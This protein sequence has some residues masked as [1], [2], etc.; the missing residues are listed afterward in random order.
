MTLTQ[1]DV[2]RIESRGHKGFYRENDG[3]DLQLLN[4]LLNREGRRLF[5]TST[6]CG[7]Y[8]IR[9]EGCRLYP[10]MLE[11]RR[12]EVVHDTFCP[13]AAEV[14]VP[15]DGEQRLRRSV[16]DE[17]HEA[18]RRRLSRDPWDR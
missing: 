4:Q 7:V 9:P 12:D 16:A 14:P 3:G 13:W 1:A 5:L 15:A 2:S 11:V 8:D 10:L 6:G 17:A 18:T